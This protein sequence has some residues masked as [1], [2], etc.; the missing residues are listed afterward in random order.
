LIALGTEILFTLG[1]LM[2]YLNVSTTK[3]QR[4]N[5]FFGLAIG[6]TICASTLSSLHVSGAVF[7]PALGTGPCLVHSIIHNGSLQFLWV[8]WVGPLTASLISAALF[9]ITNVSEYDP[10]LGYTEINTLT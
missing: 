3:Q 8:F 9:R 2:V 10:L 6:M 4:D 5:S 1:I 7:N